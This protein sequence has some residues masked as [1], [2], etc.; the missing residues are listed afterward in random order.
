MSSMSSFVA[1]GNSTNIASGS[2]LVRSVSMTP[3]QLAYEDQ[4]S[5]RLRTAPDAPRKPRGYDKMPPNMQRMFPEYRSVGHETNTLSPSTLTRGNTVDTIT[6][7]TMLRRTFSAMPGQGAGSF[8]PPPNGSIQG[9]IRV[10]DS[11]ER[12]VADL[13]RSRSPTPVLGQPAPSAP[14][15]FGRSRS[16]TLANINEVF[17]PRTDV[18]VQTLS[19]MHACDSDGNVNNAQLN[20][21]AIVEGLHKA[22]KD[23]SLQIFRFHENSMPRFRYSRKETRDFMNTLDALKDIVQEQSSEWDS[24]S[25]DFEEQVTLDHEGKS[26]AELTNMLGEHVLMGID[27]MA[28]CESP[29]FTV[30]RVVSVHNGISNMKVIYEHRYYMTWNA[31]PSV[32]LIVSASTALSMFKR[33]NDAV[34]VPDHH[35]CQCGTMIPLTAQLCGK[36][37]CLNESEDEAVN[38]DDQSNEILNRS[39]SPEPLPDPKVDATYK[40]KERVGEPYAWVE[41]GG[42]S[43]TSG[44][45]RV[46]IKCTEYMTKGYRVVIDSV[47]MREGQQIIR[48]ET[49]DGILTN[50]M[51][52]SGGRKYF[53]ELHDFH[54][55][56]E[57]VSEEGLS[58]EKP[59]S[60]VEQ[61]SGGSMS[62]QQ[63]RSR[64]A[65]L[66]AL[67]R[68]QAN[69]K[70]S[71]DLPINDKK[72]KAVENPEEDMAEE[73]KE[74]STPTKKRKVGR[75][76][77]S[78][79]KKSDVPFAGV[80]SNQT[81]YFKMHD[82]RQQQEAILTS[83]QRAN[84]V[85]RGAA[86]TKRKFT[87]R[88]GTSNRHA[89]VGEINDQ[90]VLS[91]VN[92]PSNLSRSLS[93]DNGD[94]LAEL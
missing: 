41:P 38:M 34:E 16:P 11:T 69:A 93:W 36:T 32:K 44:G 91:P 10:V 86:T 59:S 27:V 71:N 51:C 88:D 74:A 78:T 92:S 60:S 66:D 84:G 55:H 75:P 29:Q 73:V 90:G 25:F 46:P 81:E 65:S 13:K 35:P 53:A 54:K 37:R 70:D 3:E 87:T 58:K 12:I 57:L 33:V 62:E 61:T 26:I 89:V 50:D 4:R 82:E 9:L 47:R 17:S 42:W 28:L 31:N 7:G 1:K 23:E 39:F 21:R 85:K 68:A 64:L 67:Q 8:L 2:R 24:S 94:S 48:F 56:M 20:Q 63:S 30:T 6:P 80:V 45:R 79:K 18:A 40:R 15:I 22:A 43:S 5:L 76:K 77:G 14:Q 19:V 83:I 52:G 49:A 72:R